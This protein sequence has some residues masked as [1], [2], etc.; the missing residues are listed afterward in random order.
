MNN[1]YNNMGNCLSTTLE[2]YG[3]T[4]THDIN[5]DVRDTNNNRIYT[6]ATGFEPARQMPT[7][8]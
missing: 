2:A 3:I 6:S 4:L 1:K 5:T 8:F 7:D